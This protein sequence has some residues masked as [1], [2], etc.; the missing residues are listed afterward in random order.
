MKLLKPFT[1]H[2]STPVFST[3]PK[4]AIL[5]AFVMLLK[6]RIENWTVRV[7]DEKG[8]CYSHLP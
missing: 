7:M 3:N 2:F 1:V 8:K 4:R 5:A 6:G